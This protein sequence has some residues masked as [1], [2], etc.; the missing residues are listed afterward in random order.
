[1]PKRISLPTCRAVEYGVTF[2]TGKPVTFKYLR[3]TERA[4]NFGPRFGQDIEPVGRYLVHNSNPGELPA[5]WERGTVTFRRP[6]VLPLSLDPEQ[7]YGPRG[8]KALLRDHFKAR[9]RRLSC[10]LRAL[11]Y[12]GIVT[13]DRD[14]STREIVDL[15]PIACGLRTSASPKRR[16][17]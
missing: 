2:E 1:M 13:C 11:G 15:Q 17:P 7:I 10:K 14:G 3:N 6:L 5:R 9:G 16:R 8:W 12:D 4:P